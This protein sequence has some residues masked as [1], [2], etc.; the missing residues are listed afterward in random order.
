MKIKYVLLCAAALGLLSLVTPEAQA[1]P[2]AQSGVCPSIGSVSG[3]SCNV[4]IFAGANGAFSTLVTNSSPYDGIEDVLVGIVNNSGHTISSLTFNTPTGA[5]YPLFY[6]D[7][8]GLQTYNSS[9]GS[10]P[11]VYGG[12]T[13][14]GED[15]T[16][17]GISASN[18][19]GTVVFG[20]SGIANGGT[21]YFSLEGPPNVNLTPMPVPEPGS[22]AL[23]GFGLLG[24]AFAV[25]HKKQI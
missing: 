6:F 8:D 12:M 15:T 23:L 3:T 20:A 21:A 14:S 18:N 13:S 11:T 16:F 25:R 2:T 4:E 5:A 9:A 22:L 10:D 1:G 19:T 17:T 24:L 7:G